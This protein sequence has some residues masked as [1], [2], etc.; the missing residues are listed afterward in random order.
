MCADCGIIDQDIGGLRK[1]PCRGWAGIL[2]N[3]AWD[4]IRET[5]P[6]R[7]GGESAPN[8]AETAQSL[9]KRRRMALRHLGGEDPQVPRGPKRAAPWELGRN[10]PEQPGPGG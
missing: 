7:P 10:R 9:A 1:K 8:R 4:L 5:P 3:P 2:T 6:P